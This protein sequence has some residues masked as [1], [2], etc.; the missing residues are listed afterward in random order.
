MALPA[1]QHI[2]SSMRRLD[3]FRHIESKRLAG[4]LGC[5]AP[6]KI[7]PERI[8]IPTDAR[9]FQLRKYWDTGHANICQDQVMA[10]NRLRNSRSAELHCFFRTVLFFWGPNATSLA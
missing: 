6:T 4:M 10:A 5:L 9:S 1:Y 7:K 3:L 2:A 8:D